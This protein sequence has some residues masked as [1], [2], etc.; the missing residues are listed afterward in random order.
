[1]RRQIS[2]GHRLILLVA[3]QTAIATL[4]VI[5]ALK[6]MSDVA[7][8]TRYLYQYRVVAVGDMGKAMELA[9]QLQS[10]FATQ[11]FGLHHGTPARASKIVDE[12]ESF[13]QHYQEVWETAK[14]TPEAIRVRKDLFG[15]GDVAFLE[16]ED[17]A[18]TDLEESIRTLKEDQEDVEA[19][20]QIQTRWSHAR[21]VRENLAALYDV[22][23]TYGQLANQHV[24]DRTNRARNW[25]F[26][27]GALGSA[28]T[29]FLGLFVHRAISPRIRRLVT[30]VNRFR[31]FGVHEQIVETGKDEITVLA[32]ALDSGF[33]AI[34]ARERERE[35]FLGVAA[36]ELKT[37]ITSIQGYSSLLI[38]HPERTEFAPR[39]LEII[40][41]Q[42]VRLCRLIEDLFLAMRARTGELRFQPKPLDF[43]GLVQRILMEVRPYLSSEAFSTQLQP[44]VRILGD[45]ALLEHALWSLFACASAL[46]HGNRPA[47]VGLESGATRARLTIDVEGS[48]NSAQEIE[49]LFKPFQSVQYES[50]SGIRSAVGLY[51][52]REIVRVH[53]G[54]LRV[55]EASD[56]RPEFLM[57]LPA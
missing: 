37:P 10:I 22:N 28:L 27:I 38:T 32:H 30:Q 56:R 47:K 44:N 9:A 52:C 12:L 42:S 20:T 8:D 16:K 1:V 33:A 40:H 14:G 31:E 35:E 53:N 29:L 46:S 54:S 26:T 49:T 4:L 23:V 36:H 21:K 43:T 18:V 3:F 19:S 2:V 13:Y 50:G 17:K 41:R 45:E 24:I 57:E 39:A 48:E 51:L 55:R 34:A 7:A 6:A 5:T 15:T 11:S 25:L